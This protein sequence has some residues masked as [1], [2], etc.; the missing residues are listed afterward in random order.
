MG[1]QNFIPPKMISPAL[2]PYNRTPMFRFGQGSRRRRYQSSSWSSKMLDGPAGNRLAK[3]SGATSFLH[4][5]GTS[6]GRNPRV[7][8]G[9][10]PRRKGSCGI[11][12]DAFAGGERPGG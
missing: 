12:V 8:G 2:Y 4:G 11:G 6:R 3:G 9:A 7:A 5:M 10:R 1:N